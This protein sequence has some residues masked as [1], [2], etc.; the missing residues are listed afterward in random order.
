VLYAVVTAPSGT[1]TING[2]SSLIGN[3]TCDR[4]TT[5]GN[6]LLRVLQQQQGDTTAPVVTLQQPAEGALTNATQVTVSGTFSDASATTVTVNGVNATVTG[7][8]F[9]AS[10]PVAEGQNS[11][12]IA[13]TDAAGNHTDLTRHVIR[14]TTLPTIVIQQPTINTVTNVNQ[15]TVSGTF[16]DATTTTVQVNG[17]NATLTGNTFTRTVSLVEGAN[18][19]TAVAVDAAGNQSTASR[20]ITRDT[21]IP[22]ITISQPG[23][24]AFTTNTSLTVTGTYSDATATTITVNG[25]AAAL[26]GN[27][28][29]ASVPVNEGSNTLHAVAVDAVGNTSE[30]TRT[31]TRDT[32]GPTLV[33]ESPIDNSATNQ[34]EISVTGTV[35]DATATTVTVNGVS[36]TLSEGSFSAIVPITNDGQ[37]T[38]TVRATDAAGNQSSVNRLVTRD[39]VAPVLTVSSPAE[40]EIARTLS[41]AGTATDALPVTVTVVGL[42][43]ALNSSGAF[44]GQFEVGEGVQQIQIRA[45]DAAGNV[46]EI[47]RLVTID[48]TPPTI[49]ELTPAE[50]NTVDSPTAIHGIATDATAVTVQVNNNAASLNGDGSFT[51]ENVSLAEGENQVQITAQDAA[52]NSSVATLILIGRDRTGPAAPTLFT[53]TSPTRLEFQTIEGRTESGAIVSIDGG[54]TPITA[55]AAFGNGHF[56][57]NV[58]LVAGVNTLTITARDAEGNLS[59]ATQVTIDSDPS[60]AFPPAGQPAQINISIGNTQKGLV[61]TEVPRPLI[62]IV[63][64]STGQPVPGV[65]VQ[66][67]VQEGGGRFTDGEVTTQV[68][69]DLQGH[70]SVRYVSGATPGVQQI[71]ANFTGNLLTPVIFMAE[72]LEAAPGGETTVSGRVLDQNLR[73]LPNVI[74][75]IGGQQT[76]TGVDGRFVLRTVASGPHQLLELIGRDQITLP[77]RWPNITYDMDVLQGVDNDL[78][79]PLFLPRVNPGIAFP[80]DANGIVTQDT[81]VELPVVGGEPPIRITAEAGTHVTFPP[82]VTDKRLSVTRI[83]TNRVPMTLEDGRATNLYISVQPSGAIFEPALKVSFPNLDRLPAESE[84]LLMSFDHDAGRYVKVGTGHV[85]ADGRSVNSDPGSGIRVGAWH[86]TPPDPPK[87]EVT[88]LGF[89]QI[90]GNPAFDGKSIT[91]LNAWVEGTRAVANPSIESAQDS[92]RVELRATLALS[93]GEVRSAFISAD[94]TALK[95]AFNPTEVFTSIGGE[96]E[97]TATLDPAPA[98]GAGTFSWVS[99][100]AQKATVTPPT[101]TAYPSKGTVKGV[102]QGST[103]IKVNYVDNANPKIKAK[104]ELKVNIGTV[105]YEKAKDCAGFDDTEKDAQGDPIYW[106]VVGV[107]ENNSAVKVN[108]DPNDAATKGTFASLNAGVAT[109]APANAAADNQILT[110]TGVSKALTKVKTVIDGGDAEKL[111]VTVKSKKTV[112]VSFNFVSDSNSNGNGAVDH[113]TNRQGTNAQETAFAD[114]LIARLNAIWEP[115][116]NVHF[117]RRLV[118]DV[119]VA[120]NLG[121]TVETAGNQLS[122]EWTAVTALGDAQADWNIFFVWGLTI[123]GSNDADGATVR[124][125]RDTIYEDNGGSDVPESMAHEAGHKMGIGGTTQTGGAYGDYNDPLRINELMYYATDVRGCFVKKIQADVVNP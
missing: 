40:G 100:D 61:N 121:N 95:L 71:R 36:A 8:S 64:D 25:V 22:T 124:G 122:T 125:G 99:N 37:I 72:A 112:T 24:G 77:G 105:K 35:S 108:F 66:F 117:T 45:T 34:S 62:A 81:T 89:L 103:K 98:A 84:V 12:L 102:K 91:S 33:V 73:A 44:S 115:Q 54:V 120:T 13:A 11:L 14:D 4:L 69:T 29:T 55:N 78:G 85:S 80:L 116:A 31:I 28:F 68:L 60:L 83:A 38:L 58:D 96:K 104:A 88:V 17:V 118:R 59:P 41:A 111:D 53:V 106:L 19:L 30:A 65:P 39:T 15:V 101:D 57:A 76:R 123:T 63:T 90:A 6:G 5:N 92:P 42:D 32:A 75:R 21:T 2:N 3:V 56:V 110:V 20:S 114:S 97:V 94:A 86:A 47:V 113:H 46:S 1:V 70:A 7:N 119:Q 79:R 43:V 51:A 93:E 10:V 48:V 23:E 109:V 67:A 26:S 9:T 50:G 52:G 74:V 107:G 82:D 18:S 16:S 49:S 27:G 87:P